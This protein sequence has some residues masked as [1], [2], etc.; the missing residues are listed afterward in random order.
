MSRPI[1]IGAVVDI[2]IGFDVDDDC[3]G[4]QDDNFEKRMDLFPMA[5]KDKALTVSQ[6]TREIRMLLESGIGRVRVA[7]EISNLV[8]ARSGPAYFSLKDAGAQIGC[9]MWASG[10]A[11]LKF[12]P[13]EGM[14]VEVSGALSVYEPRGQYQ[15]IVSSMSEAGTGDLWNQFLELKERLE[16][17]GLFDPARKKPIPFLPRR[18]AVVTSPT[19]A[20]IHDILRVL[21]RRFAGLQLLI[22]PTLVQGRGAAQQIAHGLRRL[23][24]REDIDV[25]LLCRGGGSIEDLWAFNE[26]PVARAIAQSRIPIISGVGH[27]T[28]FTIADFVADLRAPTPSAA[29]EIVIKSRSELLD[30]LNGLDIRLRRALLGRVE[31]ARLRL[32][33]LATSYGMRRPLDRLAQTRQ[34]LD[35]LAIRL[36][37]SV[38]AALREGARDLRRVSEKL[39]ALN[40][41]SILRRGYSIVTR[42]DDGAIVA[43]P[44]QVQSNDRIQIRCAGG[45]YPALVVKAI[46]A[47]QQSLF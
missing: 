39:E 28:D 45:I 46:R 3:D 25:I 31:R 34:R 14:L 37:R 12:Q 47:Q 1:P 41:T 8:V 27:E 35:E 21:G 23:N 20:V 10:M 18:V 4:D 16:K 33:A 22:W 43:S 42:R 19:G 38:T 30:R 7:G 9:V 36:E 6:L 13:A 11:R 40:P 29:A 44:D 26:E 32:R 2:A 15:I 17:E 5:A 24:E